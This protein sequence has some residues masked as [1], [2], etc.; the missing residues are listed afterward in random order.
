[1]HF[2]GKFD[3]SGTIKEVS[4]INKIEVDL[5]SSALEDDQRQ[6]K[7]AKKTITA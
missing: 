4:P 2:P 3:S 7:T 5:I 6:H 1:M